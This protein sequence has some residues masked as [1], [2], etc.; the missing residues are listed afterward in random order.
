MPQAIKA[1]LL[2]SGRTLNFPRTGHWFIPPNF[3]AFFQDELA[4][5]YPPM[6][7][8]AALTAANSYWRTHPRVENEQQEYEHF[9]NF[10]A[11]FLHNLGV[12]PVGDDLLSALAQDAVFNDEKYAFY[13]DAAL[14]LPQLART[15]RLGLVSDAWPSLERVFIRQQLRPV[16]STFILSSRIGVTKPDA[17]MFYAA[18]DELQLSPGETL[19]VDDNLRN[20]QGAYRLGIQPVF[21]DR[22][23]QMPAAFLKFYRLIQRWINPALRGKRSGTAHEPFFKITN[24]HEL[25]ALLGE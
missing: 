20:L 16:F 23:Q 12:Q 9:R 22:D 3:T 15:F 1:I 7:I 19:F 14:V 13:P 24:L 25:A 17:R 2:D 11:L 4:K 5:K 10:Y 21:I 6:R 8:R 18:L